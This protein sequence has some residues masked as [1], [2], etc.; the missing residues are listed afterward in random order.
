MSET[1]HVCWDMLVCGISCN[2]LFNINN[3]VYFYVISLKV[4]RGFNLLCN[5]LYSTNR[6]PL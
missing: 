2:R 4:E 1:L 5:T 6:G 3:A